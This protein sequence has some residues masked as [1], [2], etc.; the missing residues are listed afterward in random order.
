M[1]NR[2]LAHPFAQ[3]TTALLVAFGIFVCIFPHATPPFSWIVNYAVQLM[4]LYLV[5][6][7][8][9]LFL[10]QPRLTF[11]C[12]GGCL[13]LSFFLK[14]STKNNYIDRWRNAILE[15]YSPK[16]E[17]LK[18]KT[19]LFN[20]SNG[21]DPAAISKAL[22]ESGADV[23]SIHEV[24]PVWEQWLVDSLHQTYPYHHTMVDI[25]LFGMAIY[26]RFPLASVD[27]FYYEEIPNLRTCFQNSG[28]DFCIVSVHTEPAL[29]E[30]SRQRLEGHLEAIAGQITR[31]DGLP[32]VVTGDFNAVSWSNELQKFM[33]RSG[34]L[35]SRSG[36]MD[37]QRTI[38]Y[39]PIDHFFHSPRLACADFTNVSDKKGNHLGIM[40]TFQLNNLATH[41]KKT[42]Q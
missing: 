23:L 2:F 5:G 24:T 42:A 31:M 8:L 13:F 29:N 16:E 14:Y 18:L 37:I 40:S 15:N 28:N 3:T 32:L 35:Q 6:G 4:L 1:L 17:V 30:F 7:V 34:L 36:F 38:S 21:N 20:L 11:L 33:E 22:R 26:S 25:G 41:V 39:V 27:T 9:F 12:F 19:G 10:K